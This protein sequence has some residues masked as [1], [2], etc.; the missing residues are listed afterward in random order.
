MK[1]QFTEKDLIDF[2]NYLMSEKREQSIENKE[3]IRKVH[4]EDIDNFRPYTPKEKDVI[5]CAKQQVR[6]SGFKP[7][8]K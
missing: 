8:D 1:K 5:K 7:K 3:N 6:E 2:G 4:Q